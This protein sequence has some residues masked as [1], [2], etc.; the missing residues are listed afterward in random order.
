MKFHSVLITCSQILVNVC[1]CVRIPQDGSNTTVLGVEPILTPGVVVSWKLL[2]PFRLDH[3]YFRRRI[4][5]GKWTWNV[6]SYPVIQ[7]K[8]KI[9]FQTSIFF[10]FHVMF[11]GCIEIRSN[12]QEN[13]ISGTP[14]NVLPMNLWSKDHVRRARNGWFL[15]WHWKRSI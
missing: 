8:R 5:S 10:R 12:P 7:L 3:N 1:V 4:R 2:L 13:N 6:K 14:S 15:H 11:R 9:I